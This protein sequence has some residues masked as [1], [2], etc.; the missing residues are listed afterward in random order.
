MHTPRVTAGLKFAP[1]TGPVHASVGIGA[2]EIREHIVY[3]APEMGSTL[4]TQK[5]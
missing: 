3:N 4:E 5:L 2:T 1:L